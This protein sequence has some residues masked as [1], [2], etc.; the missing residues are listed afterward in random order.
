MKKLLI[1]IGILCFTLGALPLQAGEPTT[2]GTSFEAQRKALLDRFAATQSVSERRAIIRQLVALSGQKAQAEKKKDFGTDQNRTLEEGN[3]S[4]NGSG[5]VA[6]STSGGSPEKN[7]LKFSGSTSALAEKK[8]SRFF[9]TTEDGKNAYEKSGSKIYV[10]GKGWVE[11][12]EKDDKSKDEKVS[13]TLGISK[14]LHDEKRE[15]AKYESEHKGDLTKGKAGV[16]FGTFDTNAKVD[17][18]WDVRKGDVSVGASASATATGVSASASGEFG[19]DYASVSGRTS[20]TVGKA[21]AKL[22]SRIGNSKDFAGAKF[23]GGVGAS[24]LEGS[25]GGSV[26][27]RWLGLEVDGSVTGSLITAEAKGTASAGYNKEEKRFEIELGGKI[28]ALLAGG[29]ANVKI[30]LNKPGWWPW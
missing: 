12:P 28:G 8:K 9:G 13:V 2:A 22:D 14:N 10:P 15:L 7:G 19:N 26:G 1:A 21:Y 17:A 6:P 11:K 18:T 29:G 25:A 5:N 16:R 24:L 20:G 27:S 4:T 30:K 23:T 3:G